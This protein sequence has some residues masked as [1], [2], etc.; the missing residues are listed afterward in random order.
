MGNYANCVVTAVLRFSS[1]IFF[2]RSIGASRRFRGF[3]SLLPVAVLIAASLLNVMCV[4][5]EEAI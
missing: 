1:L 4:V 3:F 5:K 2:A